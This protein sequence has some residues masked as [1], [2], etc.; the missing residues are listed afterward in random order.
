MPRGSRI[1]SFMANG[2]RKSPGQP[3]GR[4]EEFLRFLLVSRR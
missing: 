1:K 2:K 4:T 3:M